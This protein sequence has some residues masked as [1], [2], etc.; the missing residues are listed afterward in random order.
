[1]STRNRISRGWTAALIGSVSTVGLLAQAPT[2]AKPSP[3]LS[4]GFVSPPNPE[5]LTPREKARLALQST[6]GPRALGNRLLLAGIDQW[7]GDPET[8]PGGMEGFGRRIGF[9]MGQLAVRNSIRLGTDIAFKID[10]RY[11]RCDCAGFLNRTRHAWKRV[12]IARSD[13]GQDM[14]AFSNFTAAYI[15]P[16]IT[17]HW[18]PRELNTWDQK[19][20]GGTVHLGWRGVTNMMREFWPEMKRGIPFRRN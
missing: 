7:Q 3:L 13:S 11:D 6:I 4:T 9:R 20:Q 15:T 19:L 2:E 8:W 10:P 5:P 14:P 17:D 18:R 12:V 1:M 16:M